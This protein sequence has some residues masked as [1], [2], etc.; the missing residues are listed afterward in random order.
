[1]RSSASDRETS[2]WLSSASRNCHPI[3]R[4]RIQRRPGILG[5]QRHPDAPNPADL[6]LLQLEQLSPFE[7]DAPTDDP[8]GRR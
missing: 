7:P 1:M 5:Y 4:T 2:A 6:L 8:A 3:V